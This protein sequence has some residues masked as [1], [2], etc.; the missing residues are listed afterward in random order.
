MEADPDSAQNCVHY[1]CDTDMTTN[2][3]HRRH[4]AV[5]RKLGRAKTARLAAPA[6]LPSGDAT[7]PP[8]SV[9]SADGDLNDSTECD[10][11]DE[12]DESEDDSADRTEVDESEVDEHV[13]ASQLFHDECVVS[14]LLTDGTIRFNR[15]VPVITVVD[16]PGP[17]SEETFFNYT[18][19]NLTTTPLLYLDDRDSIAPH[20]F[21][22]TR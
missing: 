9:Q 7:H 21:T 3:R 18:S 5:R 4:Y 20:Y 6:A 10:N 8:S 22:T 2:Y 12:S 11:D 15:P 14:Q 17:S 16:Q 1:P 13:S 19:Q